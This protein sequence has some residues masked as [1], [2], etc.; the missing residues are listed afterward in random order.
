VDRYLP[1]KGPFHSFLSFRL[2]KTGFLQANYRGEQART[3]TI[4]NRN[5]KRINGPARQ[6]A[7]IFDKTFKKIF[8]HKTSRVQIHRCLRPASKISRPVYFQQ[9]GW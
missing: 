7:E 4:D 6:A 8:G 9:N 2:K 5:E 3:Q 1:K